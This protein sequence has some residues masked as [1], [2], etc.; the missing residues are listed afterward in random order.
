VHWLNVGQRQ[1][2]ERRFDCTCLLTPGRGKRPPEPCFYPLYDALG[3][4]A[5]LL[6]HWPLAPPGHMALGRL[7]TCD[8]RGWGALHAHAKHAGGPMGPTHASPRA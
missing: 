6:T 5:R 3:E 7:C 1:L 4:G 2:V 8:A